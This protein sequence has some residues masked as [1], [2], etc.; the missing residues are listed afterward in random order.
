MPSYWHALD[1]FAC[2]AFFAYWARTFGRIDLRRYLA[3]GGLLGVATLVRAQE[4]AIG[5]VLAFEIALTI[6]GDLARRPRPLDWRMRALLAL[7]GGALVV[8]VALIVFVPQLL[9]WK[10]VF[11]S[12]THLPQGPKYTRP[13]S[14]MILE[15]L[16][17]ARNG[18]FT[19]TPLAYAG[20][21]GLLFAPR[22]QRTIALGLFL[23][24][25]VQVYLASTIIDW[26]GSA[27]FGQRRLCNVTLPLVFGLA[28]L[29]ARGAALAT[30]MAPRL[31][32]AARHACVCVLLAPFCAWNI[33]RAFELR[34]GESADSEIEPCCERI[35]QPLRAVAY[36]IY[37]RI[38]NP[39]EFPANAYFALRYG[40][41]L[42]RWDRAVGD[43]PLVPPFGAFRDDDIWSSRGQWT[44]GDDSA[45]P[46]LL[47]GWSP[48]FRA[49]RVAR[50]TVTASARILVPNLMPYSQHVVVWLAPGGSHDVALRWDG[51]LVARATL[52]DGWQA[53]TFDLDTPSVGE[54]VLAIEAPP[55]LLVAPLPHGWPPVTGPTG[56]AASSIDL[57]FIRPR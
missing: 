33:G 2:A 3:L 12:A 17:S 39:F 48:A 25:A 13:G 1:A 35:S 49:E 15:L 42:T 52:H 22:R 46:Y 24:L 32:R 23:A 38:G 7:G 56:V 4:L 5:V 51:E 36:A 43:Y 41:S 27:S 11:G 40:G 8:I 31:P 53:V 45:M 55:A 44:I 21:L 28:C 47:A 16:Y 34:G 9:E 18:W 6:V 20:T 19:S 37:D 30:R 10:L 57:S 26:W 14:P 50:W 29:L 54:H